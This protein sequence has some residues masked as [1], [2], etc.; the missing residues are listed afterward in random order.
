MKC[1]HLLPS[2]HAQGTH[3]LRLIL[4]RA[5]YLIC[6]L[7]GNTIKSFTFVPA[8]MKASS[9][10]GSD[11]VFVPELLSLGSIRGPSSRLSLAP[12]Q[13]LGVDSSHLLWLEGSL[14]GLLA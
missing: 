11:S 5:E 10:L 13:S 1:F 2:G 4:C 9:G 7:S 8:V 3:I 14:L 12:W 6:Q